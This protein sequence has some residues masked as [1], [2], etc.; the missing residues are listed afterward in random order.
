MQVVNVTIKLSEQIYSPEINL[1]T[2]NWIANFFLF[3]AIWLLWKKK[4]EY[5]FNLEKTKE[6]SI[7]DTHSK[8]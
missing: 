2:L 7:F 3:P 8:K 5:R 4:I 1:L 6:N